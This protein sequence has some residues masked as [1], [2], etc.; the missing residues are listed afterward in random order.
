[1]EAWSMSNSILTEL[2]VTCILFFLAKSEYLHTCRVNL[3]LT[4]GC[5]LDGFSHNVTI[6]T[7]VS[8]HV[9]LQIVSINVVLNARFFDK[10]NAFLLLGGKQGFDQCPHG[11]KK[12]WSALSQILLISHSSNSKPHVC[13]CTTYS[14]FIRYQQQNYHLKSKAFQRL[15]GRLKQ[16][17]CLGAITNLVEPRQQFQ[18]LVKVKTFADAHGI[19]IKITHTA[20]QGSVL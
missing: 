8:S 1:M 10:N 16:N 17:K 19:L 12:Q 18:A 13:V 14:T 5:L 15:A 7:Y 9:S 11:W 6:F 20:F 4:T 2:S 3:R